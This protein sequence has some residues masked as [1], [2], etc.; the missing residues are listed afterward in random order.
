MNNS[1]FVVMAVIIMVLR[2]ER[3]IRTRRIMPISG[4][5]RMTRIL[6]EA[7]VGGRC[8]DDYIQDGHRDD[9]DCDNN[10]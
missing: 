2:L 1:V 10:G 4:R 5:K 8:D 7:V 3:K 6:M 9:V